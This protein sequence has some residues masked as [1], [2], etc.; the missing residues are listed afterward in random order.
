MTIHCYI[1]DTAVSITTTKPLEY[2]KFYFCVKPN[3]KKKYKTTLLC[4]KGGGGVLKN[5]K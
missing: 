3:T 4:K 1:I 5:G 2:I